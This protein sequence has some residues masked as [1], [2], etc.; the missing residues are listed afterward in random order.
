MVR[1]R[2]LSVVAAG[3]FGAA[4]SLVAASPALAYVYDCHAGVIS[5]SETAVAWCN[6]GTGSYRVLV[7]CANVSGVWTIGGPWVYRRHGEYSPGSYAGCGSAY[8]SNAR[9]DAR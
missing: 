1:K 4:G 7:D 5:Y 3:V 9:V 8:A 6:S 2:V